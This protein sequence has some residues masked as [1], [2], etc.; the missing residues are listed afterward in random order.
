MHPAMLLGPAITL[1]IKLSQLSAQL[2]LSALAVPRGQ[3]VGEESPGCVRSQ[4]MVALLAP[5]AVLASP[6]ILEKAE[7]L[8]TLLLRLARL[9]LSVPFVLA[10]WLCLKNALKASIQTLPVYTG[11]K[12]E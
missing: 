11:K 2:V 3:L 12:Y 8:L 1:T 4:F 7:T 6:A 5:R 10:D 9:A